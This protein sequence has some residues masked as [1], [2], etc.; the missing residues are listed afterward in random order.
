MGQMDGEAHFA[1]RTAGGTLFLAPSGAVLAGTEG[2]V[3][4]RPAGASTAAPLEGFDERPGRVNYLNGLNPAGHVSA[5]TYGGVRYRSVYPG[6][7]M[8]WHGRQGALEYDFVVQPGADPGVIAVTVEG[9]S[10]LRLDGG[11]DLIAE[12]GT[13]EMRQ[14]KPEVFQDIDGRRRPVAGAYVL[15]GGERFRFE[16][17]PYDTAAALVIDP[18]VYATFLGGTAGDSIQGVAVDSAGNAYVTGNTSSIDFPVTAG[19][20]R[21]ARNGP[22]DVFV[23]KLNPAG[24]ALL[25]STYLGG[26]EGEGS[27]G[28][29]VDGA[30]NAYLAG[31]TRST[32]L[33]VTQGAFRTTNAGDSDGF[34][35][36]LNPSG[37][38]LL[39]GSYLG[40]S[41]T[42]EIRGLAVDSAGNAYVAGFTFSTDFPVT[43]GAFQTTMAGGYDAFVTKVTTTNSGA[44]YS[45][46]VGGLGSDDLSGISVDGSGNAYATGAAA[47]GYPTT[48]GSLRP[49]IADANFRS[50]VVTKINSSGSALVYSTYLGTRSSAGAAIAVDSSGNAYVAGS[51]SSSDYPTTP[52]A[53]QTAKP[54]LPSNDGTA[55]V[56]KL[57]PAGSALVYSTWLGGADGADEPTAIRVDGTGKAYVSVKA[58]STNYPLVGAIQATKRGSFYD[59]AVS[60]LNASGAGLAFST[61]L[62]GTG[63]DQALN[64]AID[65]SSNIYLVGAT[66]STDFPTTPGVVQ[67]ALKVGD[68]G[69]N[70]GF[71]AKISTSSSAPPVIVGST[72]YSDGSN[73]KGGGAGTEVRAY[74]VGGFENVPY[75]LVLATPGCATQVAVLN[76]NT[77]FANTS[78]FIST[79]VGSIPAGLQPGP[80][81]VC[82]RSTTG[83]PPVATGTVSFTVS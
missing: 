43:S 59:A 72:W 61:Y 78:G 4:F 29:A 1:A 67:P 34:I 3:R 65:G 13:A 56:S 38:S 37:A 74:A 36:K 57:N 60:V 17:G 45:T 12:V 26:S 52:G 30:G 79:T 64:L 44:N 20:L 63:G 68:P 28:I 83:D 55:F 54:N 32:D 46:Y 53:F 22:F 62:G 23:A 81:V 69:T 27:I 42:D 19:V 6:I 25:Y 16:L 15:E 14:R 41:R 39:Y 70:D 76:P 10:S 77:R 5:P 58:N 2:S 24:T 18:L 49:T 8:V 50:G 73:A 33:P 51:S 82:F 31:L 47:S 35:A 7:D 9:A 71:V 80:Y 40:G 21:S 48:A 66:N 11:G 75:L